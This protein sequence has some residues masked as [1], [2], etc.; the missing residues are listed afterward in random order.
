MSRES[1]LGQSQAAKQAIR[2]R[3][4]RQLEAAGASPLGRA[5][6]RIPD[7]LGSDQAAAKLTELPEWQAA[8][9]VNTNPDHAQLP[10]RALALRE[11][12]QLYMAVPKLAKAQPFYYFSP[13]ALTVPPEQ[14]VASGNASAYAPTVDLADMQPI[15]LVVCGTVAVNRQGVRIGK[16]AGYSD[17]E[18]ALL[19]E[20]SLISERTTI[21]TTV[22]SLQVVDDD[23]PHD[24][25]DF[26]V[27]YIVTP[28]AVIACHNRYRPTGL[29]WENLSRGQVAAIPV[30]GE[31]AK[32]RGD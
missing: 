19:A 21:V 31:M 28:Q 29:V 24:R 4:W 3:V 25:H 18:L 6:G 5:H 23:L 16:G 11:G 12:K 20:A 14:A 9:T 7:F 32:R 2:E 8:R 13:D 30:L 26:T 15:D 10:V 27:D 1:H 22:H 17:I